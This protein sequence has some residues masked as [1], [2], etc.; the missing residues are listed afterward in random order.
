MT[1]DRL[2]KACALQVGWI[3]KQIIGHLIA[4][5]SAVSI[6]LSTLP[7]SHAVSLCVSM[8]ACFLSKQGAIQL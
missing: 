6:S 3:H 8:C 2:A 1:N 7:L 5:G 4:G